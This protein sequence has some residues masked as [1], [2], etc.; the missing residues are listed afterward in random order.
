MHYSTP[1]FLLLLYEQYAKLIIYRL[2]FPLI[3]KKP[4]YS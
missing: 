3:F 4:K 2:D 1:F